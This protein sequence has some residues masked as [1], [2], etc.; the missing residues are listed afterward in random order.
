MG[1]KKNDTANRFEGGSRDD[2]GQK[3]QCKVLMTE[4]RVEEKKGLGIRERKR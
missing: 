2:T 3:T 1:Q 4:K